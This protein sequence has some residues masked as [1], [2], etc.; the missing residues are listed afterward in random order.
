MDCGIDL[1]WLSMYP[2]E[3]E[4]LFPPLTY[5]KFLKKAKIRNSKGTIVDVVPK[6]SSS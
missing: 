4:I 3:K 1:S 5:L 6:W 2:T